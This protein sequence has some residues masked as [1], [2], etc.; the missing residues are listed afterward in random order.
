M[1][2]ET[3]RGPDRA[4]LCVDKINP[5]SNVALLDV[6]MDATHTGFESMSVHVPIRTLPLGEVIT[7]FYNGVVH[8]DG[9]VIECNRYD[10]EW[11][12]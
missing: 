6:Q 3:P 5:N 12:A 7:E 1:T 9:V 10:L 2:F 11:A 4:H 8:G